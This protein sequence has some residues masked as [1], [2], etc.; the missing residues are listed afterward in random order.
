VRRCLPPEAWTPTGPPWPGARATPDGQ[1]LK[2]V[3][4]LAQIPRI[5]ED[6]ARSVITETGLDMTRFPTA[7]GNLRNHI[8]QIQ[9][10]G[11]D[12]TITKAA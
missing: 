9:A 6:L 4:R 5:S 2:A 1:A 7:A 11:L 10:L 8:W 12:V 3:A